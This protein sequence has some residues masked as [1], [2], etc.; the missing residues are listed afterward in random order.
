MPKKKTKLAL[1]KEEIAKQEDLVGQIYKRE[2]KGT[3]ILT[4]EQHAKYN[5]CFNILNSISLEVKKKPL[6]GNDFL[7]TFKENTVFFQDLL[8][9]T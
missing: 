8:K 3:F 9:Q 1:L 5:N 2:L 6:I 4:N 7:K